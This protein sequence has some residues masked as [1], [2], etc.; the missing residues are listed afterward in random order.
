MDK[1]KDESN[2]GRTTS[3]PPTLWPEEDRLVGLWVSL[4]LRFI[5]NKP[6]L[7]PAQELFIVKMEFLA[8]LETLTNKPQEII[9]KIE[10]ARSLRELWYLRTDVYNAVCHRHGEAA[11]NKWNEEANKLFPSKVNPLR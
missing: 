1:S 6:R 9:D 4:F 3:L 8:I 2:S 10:K 11:A 5:M 7:Q